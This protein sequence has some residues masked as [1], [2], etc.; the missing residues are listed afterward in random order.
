M[1][2]KNSKIF[3]NTLDIFEEILYVI[4]TEGSESNGLVSSEN[5][6]I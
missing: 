5:H 1:L 3:T 6:E 2:C 4:D